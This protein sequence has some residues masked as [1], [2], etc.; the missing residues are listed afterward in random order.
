M[1]DGDEQETEESERD[2]KKD[3]LLSSQLVVSKWEK[4]LSKKDYS[5][6]THKAD[7]DDQRTKGKLSKERIQTE[8]LEGMPVG[9]IN[10]I[11]R[12]DLEFLKSA[13]NIVG[14]EICDIKVR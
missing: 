1:K 12:L 3:K 4:K 10:L 5:Y 14:R 6:L 7:I 13:I 2:T 11:T 8:A 9:S